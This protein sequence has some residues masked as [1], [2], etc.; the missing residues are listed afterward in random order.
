MDFGLGN[1]WDKYGGDALNA[2][3]DKVGL[4]GQSLKG[5][6]INTVAGVAPVL[7]AIAYASSQ[8]PFDTSRQRQLYSRFDPNALAYDFDQNTIKGRNQLVT[9]LANRG[10]TGSSFANQDVTNFNTNRE[11]GRSSLVNQG[12]GVAGNLANSITDADIKQRALQNDLY[13]RALLAL[14]NIFSNRQTPAQQSRQTNP[15]GDIISGVGKDLF[16]GIGDAIGGLF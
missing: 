4:G 14:G 16:G 7:A 8:G 6:D 5:F 11:L 10:L 12:I 2:I 3:L 9:S 1:I 15:F 13:G